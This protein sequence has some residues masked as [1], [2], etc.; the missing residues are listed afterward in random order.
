MCC[1]TLFKVCVLSRVISF[2]VPHLLKIALEK[3]HT[4][5]ATEKRQCDICRQKKTRISLHT[6]VCVV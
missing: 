3:T 5:R 2:D 4:R 1:Q 6:I